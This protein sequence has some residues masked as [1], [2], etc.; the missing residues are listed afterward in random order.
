[1]TLNIFIIFLST[2]IL[3]IGVIIIYN[4]AYFAEIPN[5]WN[6][7]GFNDA[8]F[9]IKNGYPEVKALSTQFLTLL[10]S[11]LVFSITFSEKVVRF[12]RTNNQAWIIFI[13]WLGLYY[14]CDYF[15]WYWISIQCLCITICFS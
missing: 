10:S 12:D 8:E 7:D 6:I 15:R 14:F 1:M 3:F 2:A 5:D 13:Y 4:F 11:I 9:F